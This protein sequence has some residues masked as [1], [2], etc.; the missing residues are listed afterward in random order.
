[1]ARKASMFLGYQSLCFT[2]SGTDGFEGLKPLRLGCLCLVLCSFELGIAAASLLVLFLL[3][4]AQPRRP[5]WR[6]TFPKIF[7]QT[8]HMICLAG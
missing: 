5:R 7:P 4:R 3:V 8:S 2:A 1:M 6:A